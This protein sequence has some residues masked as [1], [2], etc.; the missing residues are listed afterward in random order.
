[1]PPRER[2]VENNLIIFS[3]EG[4]TGRTG[5]TSSKLL[6]GERDSPEVGEFCVM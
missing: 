1:M 2:C 5:L 6:K 4:R 3:S